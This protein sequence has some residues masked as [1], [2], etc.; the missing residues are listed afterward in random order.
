MSTTAKRITPVTK[1]P[2]G[3]QEQWDAHVRQRATRCIL[4][5]VFKLG[6]I[7]AVVLGV[8]ALGAVPLAFG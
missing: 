4:W 1:R 8:L 6:L 2:Y 5:R 7:S 3:T